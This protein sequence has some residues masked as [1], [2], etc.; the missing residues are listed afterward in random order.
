M[1]RSNLWIRR[2]RENLWRGN[3][4]MHSVHYGWVSLNPT[5]GLS[6]CALGSFRSKRE[7]ERA[8]PLIK[9]DRGAPLATL[10]YTR[11]P[12]VGN[13]SHSLPSAY[14][15]SVYAHRKKDSISFLP[16]RSS[17]SSRPPFDSGMEM[18]HRETICKDPLMIYQWKAYEKEKMG[19]WL[20]CWITLCRAL[21][22]EV[23]PARPKSNSNCL[24]LNYPTWW[25][26]EYL[27]TFTTLIRPLDLDFNTSKPETHQIANQQW[28]EV[29]K[30][31]AR[32]CK[33][34]INLMEPI[35]RISMMLMGLSIGR[36]DQETSGINSRP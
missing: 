11:T 8:L 17:S 33:W 15:H 30:V 16:S 22:W 31:S 28:R 32:V 2:R 26:G 5:C 20:V 6:L 14:A 7:K 12:P 35:P 25:F 36:I 27:W 18:A 9:P 19:R 21:A 1:I 34:P 3:H 23:Y 29:P 10:T 13:F 4:C 24:R